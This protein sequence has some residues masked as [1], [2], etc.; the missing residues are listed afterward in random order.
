M[1]LLVP[2]NLGCGEKLDDEWIQVKSYVVP[3]SGG[4][5]HFT[6]EEKGTGEIYVLELR[7]QP[8]SDDP[9]NF[10]FQMEHETE[11]LGYTAG[12]FAVDERLEFTAM[13]G[14]A[15]AVTNREVQIRTTAS[16]P[17][18]VQLAGQGDWYEV[19]GSGN[20]GC[21]LN[22]NESATSRSSDF[23]L[24]YARNTATTMAYDFHERTGLKLKFN[25]ASLES[26][27]FFDW[28]GSNRDA[29]CHATHRIGVDVDLN[30]QP[31]D[32][33]FCLSGTGP[34]LEDCLIQDFGFGEAK[35]ALNILDFIAEEIYGAHYWR[36][37]DREATPVKLHYRF[38]R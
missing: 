8:P 37:H 1:T 31:V 28:G 35:P 19:R 27:G 2:D 29:K 23:L 26:G 15:D 25:D 22:H 7:P 30:R 9:T 32:A 21:D 4:H 24:P 13:E 18:M 3:G 20:A 10:V 34:R 33:S 16:L 12:E 14:E 38:Q 17:A 5:R 36:K 6:D 11:A